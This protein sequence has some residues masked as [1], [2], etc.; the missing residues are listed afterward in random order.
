MLANL[1][2]KTCFD[3]GRPV[4]VRGEQTILLLPLYNLKHDAL[5]PTEKI[6]IA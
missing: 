3:S 5:I 1:F 6:L 4:S 2:I